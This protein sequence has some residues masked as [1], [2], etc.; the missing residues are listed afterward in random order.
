MELLPVEDDL[1]WE[2]LLSAQSGATLFHTMPWLRFQQSQFGIRLFPLAVRR[3][4][5]DAGVFPLFVTRRWFLRVSSSPRGIDTLHLG[6][7]VND[8]LLPELLDC[9]E[10]WALAGGIDY[11][12]IAFVKE[13][14]T[15]PA[16]A[17]GYLCERH[18]HAVIDL[19]GGEDAAFARLTSECRRRIRLAEKLGVKIIEGGLSGHY[20]RYLELSAQVFARS[21]MKTALTGNILAAMVDTLSSQGRLLALRAEV[22]G[23]V[24]GMWIGGLHGKTMFALDAVSDRA[25]VQ[26][27]VNNL[28]NW[29]ALRWS[30]RRGLD[31]LDFGGSRI[32]SLAIFKASFGAVDRYYTNIKKAHN[33]LARAAVWLAGATVNKLRAGLFRRSQKGGVHKGMGS[34]R[35]TQGKAGGQPTGQSNLQKRRPM[36]DSSP[37][38]A[39][40]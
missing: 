34:R 30:C 9:Y 4:D 17:R 20:G 28:I 12:T 2:Q 40:E 16:A 5:R 7:L 38:E 25:F 33:P 31:M 15:A 36:P 35:Y 29:H 10:R 14:D 21:N 8:D 13:I 6:P 39:S 32:R 11:T 37:P 18:K 27:S 24:A 3:E 1:Q 22:G 26:Y 23:Q 19:R